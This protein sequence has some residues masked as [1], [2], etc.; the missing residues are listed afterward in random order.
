MEGT[1]LGHYR[2]VS[3]MGEGGMGV[4]WRAE[5]LRM[6]PQVAIKVIDRSLLGR[7]K[8]MARFARELQVLVELQHHPNIVRVL[9]YIDA[10]FSI[11][12]ELLSGQDLEQLLSEARGPLPN[13]KIVEVGRQIVSAVGFAHSRNILHR[14]LKSGNV[15]VVRLGTQDAVK[16]MDFGLAGFLSGPS[17]LSSAGARMGTPAYMAPE[18]HLDIRQVDARSD[19]YSI[20]VILYEMATGRLPFEPPVGAS[21]YAMMR[22]HLEQPVPPPRDLNPHLSRALEAVILQA[23]AKNKEARFQGCD[24]LL[25]AL[26]AAGRCPDEVPV[27]VRT[28]AEETVLYSDSLR[29]RELRKDTVLE[30]G[31]TTTP[32]SPPPA[33]RGPGVGIGL[34][35]AALVLVGVVAAAVGIRQT[36]QDPHPISTSIDLNGG[37]SGRAPASELAPAP[38]QT[39]PPPAPAST[40]SGSGGGPRSP[41]TIRVP[42]PTI[43]RP[44]VVESI[45]W[46]DVPPPARPS[47]EDRAQ[48]LLH[49]KQ[50]YVFF[51]AKDYDNATAKWLDVIRTWSGAEQSYG[52]LS[53]GYYFGRRYERCLEAAHWCLERVDT[54]RILGACLFNGGMCLREM[55]RRG[56]AILAFRQSLSYRENDIVRSALRALESQ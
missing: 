17:D 23:L 34:G 28:P 10:P 4:V 51:R 54:P 38:A 8:A 41:D 2:I 43:E 22:A 3:R 39:A 26:E 24:A 56:E 6:G 37:K 18:Q 27:G 46:P 53:Y 30:D 1:T 55:G 33:R 13:A 40:E 50:A 20:G 47:R 52:D 44:S 16:V 48:A 14:D 11:V 29:G 31:P 35:L 42:S 9:D 32:P 45:S 49:E 5:D 36:R 19:I 12:M 15:F 21:D 7:E 25:Q